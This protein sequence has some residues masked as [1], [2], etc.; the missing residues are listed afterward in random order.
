MRKLQR[1]I[2]PGIGGAGTP[3]EIIDRLHAETVKAIGY[4]DVKERLLAAGFDIIGDPPDKFAQYLKAEV[5]KWAGVV[6]EANI[7]MD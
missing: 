3:R 5:P 1:H 6:R 4:P 2:V 7:R